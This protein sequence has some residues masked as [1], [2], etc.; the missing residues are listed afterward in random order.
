MSE[1]LANAEDA[2]AATIELK[3]SSNNT[4]SLASLLTSVPV[5]PIA[6]PISACFKAGAS[7]TPS[8]VMATSSPCC[9]K[10][11]TMRNLCSG[12]TRA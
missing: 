12:A 6:T 5:I 3:L 1:T 7:F 8:P 4:I 11:L 9:C 10:A 2:T